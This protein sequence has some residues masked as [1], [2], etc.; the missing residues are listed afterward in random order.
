MLG[1]RFCPLLKVQQLHALA[2]DVFYGRRGRIKLTPATSIVGQFQVGG[3]DRPH[4]TPMNQ[5]ITG[6]SPRSCQESI[7]LLRVGF[8]LVKCDDHCG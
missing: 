7:H 4:P 2:R 3:R 6:E 8:D 1:L 5:S